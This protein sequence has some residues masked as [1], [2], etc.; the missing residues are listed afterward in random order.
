MATKKYRVIYTDALFVLADH[1]ANATNSIAELR[2][3]FKIL[4]IGYEPW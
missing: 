3:K 1:I 2:S 4:R